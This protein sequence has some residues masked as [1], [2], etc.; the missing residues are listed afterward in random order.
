MSSSSTDT[1]ERQT[2]QIDPQ[3]RQMYLDN[4]AKAQM[5]GADYAKQDVY[6][7]P[8]LN[9][10]TG[11]MESAPRVADPTWAVG[12]A[13][14]I[15][16]NMANNL[17]GAFNP[18]DTLS[19]AEGWLN[20]AFNK[21][22]T[23]VGAYGYDPTPFQMKGAS[24]TPAQQQLYQMERVGTAGGPRTVIDASV[25][26]EL[27]RSV[28]DPLRNFDTSLIRDV[29]N[30]LK[31]FTRST[32]QDVKTSDILAG[33]DQ[34]K[35]RYTD[36][37]INQST[38]DL[39]RARQ[40]AQM[41]NGSEAVRTGSFGG[42]RHGVV[43][44][45][46]NRGFA[47]ATARMSAQERSNAFNTA[48]GLSGQDISNRMTAGQS[49]QGADL[50]MAGLLKDAGLSAGQ[51]NTQKDLQLAG[52]LQQGGLTA[53]QANTQRDLTMANMIGGNRM[54]AQ[55][56]NQNMD[57][58]TAMQN[59]NAMMQ[60]GGANTDRT[61]QALMANAGYGQQ[62]GLSNQQA[63]LDASK[64]NAGAR[65]QSDMSNQNAGFQNISQM[66]AAAG[67]LPGIAQQQ[68]QLPMDAMQKMLGL[69]QYSRGISQ[70]QINAL[71]QQYNER[72][73]NE[74]LPLQLQS[75]AL[76]MNLPNLGMTSTGQSSTQYNP[77]GLQTIGQVAGIVG[78]LAG[79]FGG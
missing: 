50:A 1:N 17:N 72:R 58:N 35:N 46:T 45:E 40:I 44:G 19:R 24:L 77:S 71:M 5:V 20:T 79:G 38:Q 41:Q 39:N 73:Q 33:M 67:Q 49:N 26:N 74:L 18:A 43:E 14:E 4:F 27:V 61:M 6:G 29:N 34:Y 56:A 60:G 69:D 70:E 7:A 66:L 32:I 36:D 31:N 78:S 22:P 52:M 16:G 10:A 11:K 64:Y 54:Q 2:T 37:V 63:L 51:A 28:E 53:G 13:S 47:D 57:Y 23:S 30:P 68:Y 55:L 59:L 12:R 65:T 42:G 76:G 25:P 3:L 9:P 8:Q 15:G 62:A 48:A 75:S 21:E